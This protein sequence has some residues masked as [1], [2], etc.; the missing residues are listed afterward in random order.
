MHS[1]GAPHEGHGAQP[2]PCRPRYARSVAGPSQTQDPNANAATTQQL[3]LPTRPYSAAPYME[4][5]SSG[6]KRALGLPR[7]SVRTAAW[8]APTLV[9]HNA[10]MAHLAQVEGPLEYAQRGNQLHSFRHAGTTRQVTTACL[11]G[12]EAH[13]A[14]NAPLLIPG[15]R[16]VGGGHCIAAGGPNDSTRADHGPRTA[17]PSSAAVVRPRGIACLPPGCESAGLPVATHPS[18]PPF[19]TA[20]TLSHLPCWPADSQESPA[21]GGPSQSSESSPLVEL[22]LRACARGGTG[23]GGLISQPVG[24]SQLYR[25]GKPIGEGSFGEAEKFLCHAWGVGDLV[26]NP[27]NASLR[28]CAHCS[29]TDFTRGSGREDFRKVPNPRWRRSPPI[30]E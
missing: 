4:A 10:G 20:T 24:I 2:R 1:A 11:R 19:K 12:L 26:A 16:G 3:K 28:V 27:G 29:R 17:R 25:L 30:G 18:R 15:A 22:A 23:V 21:E 6:S 9:P 5:G 8:G 7:S 14:A 13:Q